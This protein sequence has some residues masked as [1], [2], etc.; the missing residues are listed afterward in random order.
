MRRELNAALKSAA[1][2]LKVVVQASAYAKLPHH[3]GL[4]ERVANERITVSVLAG[5]PRTA[6]VRLRQ[7][8]TDAAATNSGYVRHP[9]PRGG[10]WV[11]QEIPRAAGWWTD[12]LEKA[13]PAVTPA[14]LAVMEKVAA[15][16][17]G[18]H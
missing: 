3:G 1:E 6:G 15:Q 11:R 12:P 16:I 5:S 7:P 14:I 13:G 17:Q 9:I 4:N 2:P 18:G 8:T 10:V